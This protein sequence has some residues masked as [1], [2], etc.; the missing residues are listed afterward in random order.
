MKGNISDARTQQLLHCIHS[1]FLPNK[2]LILAQ[3]SASYL[4]EKLPVLT[5]LLQVD[6]RPTVYVCQ[7]YTCQ[8]PV[9]T[10][11]ELVPL[12]VSD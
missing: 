10:V 6:G 3:S 1:H 7:N 12:L 9:T 8:H 11:D 4:D 2:V 5:D